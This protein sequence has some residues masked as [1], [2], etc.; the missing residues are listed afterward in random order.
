MLRPTAQSVVASQAPTCKT[1]PLSPVV[2]PDFLA[3]CFLSAK[4]HSSLQPHLAWLLVT[5]R[6]AG[7]KGVCV[8]MCVCVCVRVCMCVCVCVC[9]CMHVCVFCVGVCVCVL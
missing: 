2:R 5:V 9:V 7:E 6:T 4:Q 3:H 1:I 8:C